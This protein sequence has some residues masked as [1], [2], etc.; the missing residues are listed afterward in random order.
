M[1]LSATVETL[2]ANRRRVLRFILKL[3]HVAP[4]EGHLQQIS[5]IKI[6]R[7]KN[8]VRPALLGVDIIMTTYLPDYIEL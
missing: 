6:E 3:P 1:A 5:A 8:F 7:E 2:I 4:G